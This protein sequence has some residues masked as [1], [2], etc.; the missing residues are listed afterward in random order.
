M[1]TNLPLILF[2]LFAISV[3]DVQA[4]EKSPTVKFLN[5]RG[6]RFPKAINRNDTTKRKTL[7]ER[8]VK[9]PDTLYYNTV[10]KASL[11]GSPTIPISFSRVEKGAD[12]KYV[13]TPTLGIGYGYTWF[14]GHIIFNENDKLT[15][16]P[17]FFFGF[18]ADISLQ[19]DFNL[20]KPAGFFTGAF[21]G[22]QAFSIFFGY[23]Y[24]TKSFSLG[25]GGRVD[26]YT[27]AQ[28]TLRPYG[29][30]KDPEQ[31]SVAH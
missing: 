20:K 10:Y 25:V 31:E 8:T 21:I 18:V 7:N 4:Q 29:R 16:D 9:W 19:S 15:V 22:S 17:V 2:L 30:V 1:K 26:L 5:R 28:R 27:I 11:F 12:G 3:A 23:D 6:Y 24:I 13:V 14:F